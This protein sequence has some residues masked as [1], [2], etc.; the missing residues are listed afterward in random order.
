MTRHKCMMSRRGPSTCFWSWAH[1]DMQSVVSAYVVYFWA[2][3]N[4]II[5]ENLY[6]SILIVVA[7]AVTQCTLLA[8]QPRQSIYN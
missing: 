7:L 5:H 2:G 1:H 8:A 3:R 6:Q 4:H